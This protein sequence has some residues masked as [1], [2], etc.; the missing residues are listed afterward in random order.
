MSWNQLST[1]SFDPI[2]RKVQFAG[3]STF[4][5]SL[6]KEW[7]LE[8]GLEPG[9]SMSL[10]PHEDRLVAA[11]EPVSTQDRTVAVDAD[12]FSEEAVTRRIEAAYTGG[13]DR[14]T[15][16]GL[17]ETNLQLRRSIQQ[18]VNQLTGAAI[19]TDTDD[20]LTIVNLLD[21]SEIS[22]PQT[23]SQAQ[24][25]ALELHEDAIDAFV[26]NDADLARRVIDRD[27]DVDRLFSFVKHGINRGLEDVHEI[28]RLGTDRPS[29]FRNYRIAQQLE[30]IADHAEGIARETTRQSDSP[31]Q[32]F[33]DQLETIG[34]DTRS[35]IELALAGELE[36]AHETLSSVHETVNQ[37]D[38]ELYDR[39][40]PKAYQYGKVLQL[41]HR[42]A[43]NGINI[44]EAITESSLE[45]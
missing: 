35:V 16:I 37:I 36:Q 33:A 44:A 27:D 39:K 8:Q 25:L 32:V 6:P 43:E 24:Q 4:V 28:D 41:V 14:I 22:L 17:D 20:R 42:T 26:T 1:S 5:I 30:R 9:M 15:V 40:E 29:M 7:A 13:C 12:A 19:R 34:A 2:E 38:Q 45:S 3:N 18:T 11:T 10:Y 31:D 21:S 23:V